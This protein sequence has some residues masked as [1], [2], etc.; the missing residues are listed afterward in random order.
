MSYGRLNRDQSSDAMLV[1]HVTLLR[2][3]ELGGET[4]WMAYT[5][6]GTLFV[7]GVV[8]LSGVGLL[9]GGAGGL[10]LT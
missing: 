6:P 1:S 2:R 8:V 4:N 5:A 3:R 7:G 10:L 9:L